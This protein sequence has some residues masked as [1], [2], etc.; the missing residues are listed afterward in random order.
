MEKLLEKFFRLPV[1]HPKAS[2]AF[3]AVVTLAALTGMP[4]LRFEN[5]LEVMMPRTDQ[6]YLTYRDAKKV[7]GNSG[8]FIILDVSSPE[9]FSAAAFSEMD[10]LITDIEQFS[11]YSADVEDAR[12]SRI[13]LL[14]DQKKTVPCAAFIESLDDDPVFSRLVQRKADSLGYSGGDLTPG[15]L[16][17][18]KQLIENTIALKKEKSVDTI[19][20][21]LT[22][23]DLT[24]KDDTLTAYTL[25]PL[26]ESGKRILPVSGE[27]FA[28]FE[29]KL[30]HNPAFKN[31][32]YSESQGKI[33]DF[34]IMVRLASKTDD[35]PVTREIWNIAQ[36]YNNGS[37]KI[38][39][40]GSPILYKQITD[41]M[42][43]DLNFFV[44]LVMLVICI[45][46]FINFGTVQGVLLPL[47]TLIIA[48]IWTLGLMGH[49]GV[50][51]SVIGI[52]L[53]PLIISVGSSYSIH[54]MNRFYMDK[55]LIRKSG[56]P[57]LMSSMTRIGMTL[58]LASLTTII[59]FAT[60]MATRVSAIF[61]WGIFAA[62]GTLFAVV[63]ASILIPSVFNYISIR[64]PRRIVP[65]STVK[66]NKKTLTDRVLQSC[67]RVSV[68]HPA[69]IITV[70]VILVVMSAAGIVRLKTETSLQSYFKPDDYINT[71]NCEIGRK[72]G[73]TIGIDIIV[74]SGTAEGAKDPEFLKRTEELRAWLT[75]PEN[76]DLHIG[77][78]DAFG[79]FVKTMNMAMHNDDA[80]YYSIPDS[81]IDLYDYFEIYSGDDNNSD[82]RADDL[83]QYVDPAFRRVSILARMYDTEGSMLGTSDI[84]RI[85][86]RIK[87]HAGS[88][89]S[90]YGYKVTVTGEQLIV[91]SLAKY[92]VQGQLWSLFLSL[93]AV[94]L[95]VVIL[96]RS[97]RAGF[98]S[99]IPITA[100]VI[101]N[102]GVMGWAGIHL[103]I[104]TAIIASI[105]VG[106]G[107][108]NTIHFLNNYRFF[109]RED[110]SMDD[111]ITSTISV[112]GKAIIY[113]ALALI[114]G[115][116]VLVVSKFQPIMLFGMMMG[117]TF[118][119][120][121]TGALLVLP[122][123][124]KLTG[125]RF[126]SKDNLKITVFQKGKSS[127]G[128]EEIGSAEPEKA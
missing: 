55:E 62:L 70:T 73:G 3:L 39:A 99:A 56:Q 67:A 48:D 120:T 40:Q 95:V 97:Y 21:P 101:V 117:F 84:S 103:D 80:A 92:I 1:Y 83:E 90:Q 25:I 24:G 58:L 110:R 18:L 121:T 34:G 2:L 106:I 27:D 30:R 19:L 33:T 87:A 75:S 116:S 9:L 125:F 107:V 71:S 81:A 93:L 15:R 63:I 16:V 14:I 6:E 98:I 10:K 94:S 37:M 59:G 60:N 72:F 64:E 86:N 112:G 82:G 28:Q 26:D 5:S 13:T 17:R 49:L 12:L 89:L 57:G 22:M 4:R 115:F 105:T 29:S 76:A 88:E 7:F 122:A 123:A 31:G 119:A 46:F 66:M 126:S 50:K 52:S 128:D 114:C 85:V 44:P 20:S 127:I 100:A 91:M 111:S 124:V 79:D 41:Y 8:K 108:D 11:S 65:E 118:I 38:T 23:K 32:I 113:S 69:A 51:I 104:A 45:I 102:F 74:D 43:R 96:F 42:Q 61:E 35:D 109:C 53:A 78:T 77:R 47:S 54:I 36:S 68:N